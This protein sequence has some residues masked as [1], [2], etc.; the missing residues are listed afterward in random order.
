MV[1]NTAAICIQKHTWYRSL[2]GVPPRKAM[3]IT[4]HGGFD[5]TRTI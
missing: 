5:I 2:P 4:A 3:C 1:N